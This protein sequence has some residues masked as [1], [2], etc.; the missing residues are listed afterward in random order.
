[1]KIFKADETSHYY[2]FQANL[3]RFSHRQEMSSR[4]VLRLYLAYPLN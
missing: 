2:M 4:L 3:A 1:M